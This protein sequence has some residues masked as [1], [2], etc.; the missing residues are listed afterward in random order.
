[1]FLPACLTRSAPA[2][3]AARAPGLLTSSAVG[4]AMNSTSPAMSSAATTHDIPVLAGWLNDTAIE[5]AVAPADA[6]AEG[7]GDFDPDGDAEGDDPDPDVDP[8]PDVDVC[9]G[10]PV[11]LA[12]SSAA[13]SV[14]SLSDCGN[15]R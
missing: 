1:M 4:P 6:D 15:G 2:A 3:A 5:C 8:E 9:F 11:W 13:L 14:S 10:A 7:E 12:T